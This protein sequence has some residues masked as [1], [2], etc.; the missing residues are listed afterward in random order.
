MGRLVYDLGDRQWN[1]LPLRMLLAKVL[2]EN[3][4]YVSFDVEHG[5]YRDSCSSGLL[6]V[7]RQER[8]PRYPHTRRYGRVRVSAGPPGRL[9]LLCACLTEVFCATRQR[10]GHPARPA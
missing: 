3:D 1:I 9:K 7:P 8:G 6:S 10:S 5:H 2:P 4:V